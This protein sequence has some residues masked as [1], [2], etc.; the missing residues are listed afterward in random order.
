MACIVKQG[1]GIFNALQVSCAP[2][3]YLSL[4]ITAQIGMLTIFASNPVLSLYSLVNRTIL[5]FRACGPGEYVNGRSCLTCSKDHYNLDA[6]NA[7]SCSSCL[8]KNGALQCSGDQL[9]VAS[10]YWRREYNIIVQ[11]FYLVFIQRVVKV[12]I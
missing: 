11:R 4:E 12:A 6:W 9:V 3:G 2:S 1:R 7:D 5:Q 8:N 10:G